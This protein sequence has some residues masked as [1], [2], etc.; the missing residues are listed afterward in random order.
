M[1][2]DRTRSRGLHARRRWLAAAL[3]HARCAHPHDQRRHRCHCVSG[4]TARHVEPGVAWPRDHLVRSCGITR[5]SYQRRTLPPDLLQSLVLASK[6]LTW[7]SG[8]GDARGGDARA[9]SLG[10]LYTCRAPAVTLPGSNSQLLESRVGLVCCRA[11]MLGAVRSV[12]GRWKP[13]G[14]R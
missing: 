9:V 5:P 1:G 13:A 7:L 11:W 4:H 2:N 14:L 6:T 8:G 10:L 12:G 3:P